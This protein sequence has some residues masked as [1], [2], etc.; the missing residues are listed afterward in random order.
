M[1]ACQKLLASELFATVKQV[2]VQCL[3]LVGKRCRDLL[4]CKT[5]AAVDVRIVD[6]AD[7]SVAFANAAMSMAESPRELLSTL[8]ESQKR[9]A[10]Q[11]TEKNDVSSR[12]H[13]IFQI[14]T[15]DGSGRA[16]R[17]VLTLIDCAGTERRNDSLFHGK[18]R[19]AESAEINTSLYALKVCIRARLLNASAHSA[20][21]RVRV[22]YRSSN[23]T[24]VLRESLECSEA[25]LS[26]IATIAPN[27][28]DTEHTIQTLTTLSNLTGADCQ[29]GE[30]QKLSSPTV[31]DTQLKVPPKKWSHA[32][33][34]AWLSENQLSG[35]SPVS[36]QLDGSAVMR[37]SKI[38][39]RNAFY[40]DAVDHADRAVAVT[41]A[42]VLFQ[43]LRAE[44]DRVASLDLKRRMAATL[45]SS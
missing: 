30:L 7:G 9:R 24:R 5:G 26:V 36:R 40:D 35:K 23:L 4:V 11:S 1:T 34:I 25:R 31:A 37:M 43:S 17:G 3:E 20:S 27:A 45:K 18:E 42:E 10:T 29:E 38:Q 21:R 14:R 19:Q 15:L 2:Q 13:A 6:M 16:G 32:D 22:P 33:L 28:T 39:L 44:S 41:Q 12:S 8:V